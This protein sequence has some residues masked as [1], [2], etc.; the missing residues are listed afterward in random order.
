MRYS[1]PLDGIRAVAVLAVLIFH[2]SP[3]ALR[4]GFTGVD[5]FFVLSGYLIASI[6][7]VDLRKGS[8]S[9]GEFYK[10]RIQRLLPNNLVTVLAVLLLWALFMPPSTTLQAADHGLWTIFDLSNIYVWQYLGDYWESAAKWSPLTHTWSLGIEEQYYLIFPGCLLLLARF[11]AGRIRSWLIA[12]TA[13]S[14]ALCLLM[15]RNHPHPAFY[16]L[17]TRMWELLIGAALAAHLRPLHNDHAGIRPAL[18]VHT[19]EAIGLVGFAAIILGFIF[20]EDGGGFPGLIALVPTVGTALVL[21]SV[22]E[23]KTLLSRF[24]STPPMVGI[25]A[26]SFSIYLWHWP[27][28]IFGKAQA[29]LYGKP[30]IYGS[31]AGGIAGVLL[32]G[33][34]YVAVERPLRG[35]GPGRS[36]R[37][38][39]IAIGFSVTAVCCIV[40]LCRRPVADPAHLFDT[41]AF[42]G[43]EY[44]AGNGE[45]SRVASK[46]SRYDVYFPPVA[47]DRPVDLWRTGGVVHL[48]GGGHPRVVVLGSSH[49]LMYSNVIDDICRQMGVSVAFLGVDQTGVFFKT[50]VNSSF[51][52]AR[53]A[54]EFDQARKDRL[55]EWHP[56]LVFVIDRWDLSFSQPQGFDASLRS[57]LSEVSP[58]TGHVVFVAQAPVVDD[59][60]HL[61]NLRELITWHMKHDGKMPLFFP[62]RSEH[63]R[64]QAIAVAEADTA[65]FQNLSILRADQPFYNPDGSIRYYAGKSC[66]YADGDHLSE[67]GAEQ[68]RDL[69]QSAIA[70]ANPGS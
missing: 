35:R 30:E 39:V 31:V 45:G 20:I 13:L 11:Q 6:I 5:V 48:Y 42:L 61:F 41:P 9:M 17:P 58:K 28:I 57:F 3:A 63:L 32:A 29:F 22:A 16:L 47:P 21:F 18:A 46:S 12:A 56:D 37:F 70:K 68:A 2:I 50:P 4:G 59:D 7:L 25:G 24:L 38:A 34:T 66:F 65:T 60:D 15:V 55:R 27:L 36:R 44:S 49:A 10:R 64:R 54:N 19:Q 43:E 33:C 67:K 23:E 51:P 1:P 40:L 14:F 62:D 8:F 52:T 53:V 26:L 69:F